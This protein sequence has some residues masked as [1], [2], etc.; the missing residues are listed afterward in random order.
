LSRSCASSFSGTRGRPRAIVPRARRNARQKATWS[1]ERERAVGCAVDARHLGA[2]AGRRKRSAIRGMR[3]SNERRARASSA[4]APPPH[5]PPPAMDSPRHMVLR[6][7]SQR[8]AS[9]RSLCFLEI[10]R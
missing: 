2:L 5:F 10:S 8:H 7:R 1:R 9:Q 4:V 3:R 6:R